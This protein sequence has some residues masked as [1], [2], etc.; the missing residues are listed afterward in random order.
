MNRLQWLWMNRVHFPPLTLRPSRRLA[1]VLLLGHAAVGGVLLLLP[2]P[3]LVIT[4]LMVTL[5]ASAVHAVRVQ[6]LRRS[7]QA[8]IHLQFSDREHLEIGRRDGSR[9]SGR[10]LGSSTAGTLLIVLNIRIGQRRWPV[11]VVVTPDSL[12]ADG[13]RSLRVWLRWGPSPG[14]GRAA[15]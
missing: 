8:V 2:L 4:L 12:E 6:A 5:A 9:A 3:P 15:E 14:E 1:A 7:P 11:H 10:I 13:F